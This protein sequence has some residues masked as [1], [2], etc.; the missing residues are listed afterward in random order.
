MGMVSR[1][2]NAMVGSSS[3]VGG[4]GT[5]QYGIRAHVAA[6]ACMSHEGCSDRGCISFCPAEISERQIFLSAEQ[7]NGL[8]EQTSAVVEELAVPVRRCGSPNR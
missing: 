7:S 2:V 6:C 1:M 8:E 3:L 4:M 5:W